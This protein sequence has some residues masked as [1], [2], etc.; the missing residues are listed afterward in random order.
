MCMT[1][2]WFRPLRA[3]VCGISFVVPLYGGALV[4]TRA[5]RVADAY[6]KVFDASSGTVYYYNRKTVRL[7]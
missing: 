7:C 2:C 4:D 6:E 3:S 1:L 5:G